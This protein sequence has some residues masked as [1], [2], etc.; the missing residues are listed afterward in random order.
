MTVLHIAF[1]ISQGSRIESN[2][3][4]LLRFSKTILSILMNV[5]WIQTRVW[6]NWIKNICL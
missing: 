5:V 4:V 6:V 2:R 3:M 1:L